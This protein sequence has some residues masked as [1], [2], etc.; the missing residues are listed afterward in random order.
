MIGQDPVPRPD[1]RQSPTAQALQRGVLRYL[2]AHGLFGLPE[3]SL[4][5]GRRADLIAIDPKGAITIVEIKS[6]VVDFRTDGKW[7]DYRLYCDRLLFAVPLDFPVDILPSEVGILVG[8]A[9]GAELL[10]APP[11]HPLPPATRKA[12]TLRFARAAAGRLAG[13]YDPDLRPALDW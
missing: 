5:S 9:F 10:R 4:A 2:V 3:L 13:L 8:D 7:P 6:S 1:G 12:V 11:V